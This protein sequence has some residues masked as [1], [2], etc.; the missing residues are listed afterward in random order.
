MNRMIVVT[1]KKDGGT[2]DVIGFYHPDEMPAVLRITQKF[3]EES[4]RSRRAIVRIELYNPQGHE[5]GS[6]SLAGL[7]G[8]YVKKGD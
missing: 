5:L 4:S 7:R 1:A 8:E 6:S 3:F 2:Q